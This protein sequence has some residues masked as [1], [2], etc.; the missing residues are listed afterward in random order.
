MKAFV[1]FGGSIEPYIH[2][3]IPQMVKLFENSPR[4]ISQTAIES[5]RRISR[6]I[7]LSEFSPMIIQPFLRILATTDSEAL[8]VSAMNTICL[9]LVQM[10]NE[11]KVF[12]PSITY[13]LATN[14]LQFQLYDHLVDKLLNGEPLPANLP[15]DKDLENP[16]DDYNEPDPTP[17][18][19]PVNPQALISA[20]E[21]RDDFTS[22]DWHQWMRRLHIDMLKESPSPCLRACLQ[23]ATVHQPLAKEL[24]NCAFVSCWNEL[25]VQYQGEIAQY[26]CIAFQ[27]KNNLPEVLQSLLNLA[28]FMEHD[29]KALPIRTQTMAEFAQR[30]HVYAKALHYK[31]VESIQEDSVETTEALIGINNQLQ[32]SDSAVGILKQLTERN[33]EGKKSTPMQESWYEKLQRWDDAL[34]AYNERE[35]TDPDSLDVMLGKMRCLHALGEWETLSELAKEKWGNASD[36]IKRSMAPLA[37]ASAWGLAQWERMDNYIGAMKDSSADKAF[38]NAILNLHKNNFKEGTN[39]IL[40]AR[41]LLVAEL[42]AMVSESYNR[43]YGVVVRVQ[44][45]SELEEIVKYKNLPPDSERRV[46]IRETWNKRLLGCQRNVDIWQ[47]LLKWSFWSC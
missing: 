37:A 38:F 26:L 22:E 36:D 40:K 1:A 4:I 20:C 25:H 35:K 33:A 24:F 27:S 10:G 34:E 8:K 12:V 43:A 5:V 30:S 21:C 42:T 29:E 31:E 13:V 6:N 2:L 18:K 19:L 28:E 23:L 32:Q 46:T 17:R 14:K 45:L 7:N 47:R 9:F 16:A 39:Q 3:I 44:M 11:F 41:E 15:I